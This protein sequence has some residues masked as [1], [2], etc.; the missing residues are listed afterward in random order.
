MALFDFLNGNKKK[1]EAEQKIEE[2]KQ[3]QAQGDHRRDDLALRQGGDEHQRD[4]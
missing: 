1:A 2:Q 4:G 3:E